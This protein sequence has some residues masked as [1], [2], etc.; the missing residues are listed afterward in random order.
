MPVFYNRTNFMQVSFGRRRFTV[1]MRPL[2]VILLCVC[3]TTAS[4]S[5]GP[6]RGTQPTSGSF[7]QNARAAI[8]HGRVAEAESLARTQPAGDAEAAAVLARLA[9]GRGQYDEA[10]RLL[11]PAAT[12]DPAGEAALELG[13]LH[14]WF[15]RREAAEPFLV[16]VFRQ[17]AS[18]SDPEGL[19]RAAR[20][21]RA[22]DRPHDAN[23]LFRTAAAAAPN[24]AIET[25][26]G[27]LLLEKHQFGEALKSFKAALAADDKWAPALAGLGWTLSNENPP[28]AA[29]A[30]LRAIAIDQNLASARFNLGNLFFEHSDFAAAVDQLTSYTLLQ[31]RSLQ[32][33]LKLGSAQIQMKRYDAAERSFKAALELHPGSCEALNGLGNVSVYRRR[34]Q[35]AVNYF[36]RALA[37]DTNYAPAVLNAAILAHQSLNNRQQALQGYRTYAALAPGAPNVAGSVG[38]TSSYLP[39]STIGA[40]RPTLLK[41]SLTVCCAAAVA[42]SA[43]AAANADA[44]R[45]T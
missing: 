32:A 16:R 3:A 27:E 4:S 6:S 30:A 42:P 38:P 29:E 43:K 7:L 21:A 40:P 22:L 13:I 8:A 2:V 26:W 23:A 45:K 5:F 10:R 33:W 25:S 18:N 24:P 20:A 41:S 15:G 36:N 14:Q 17:G 28:A 34:A 37:L 11:E 44:L 35:D 19:F 9:L 1:S 31:P 12:A 39:R